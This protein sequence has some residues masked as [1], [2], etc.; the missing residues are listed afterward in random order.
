MIYSAFG[1]PVTRILEADIKKNTAKI[2]VYVGETHG[3]I[4]VLDRTVNELRADNGWQEIKEAIDKP[5]SYAPP[6]G[7]IVEF[8]EE[9]CK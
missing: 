5:G 9:Y 4:E 6:I 7:T 2:E 1:L 3:T 8:F